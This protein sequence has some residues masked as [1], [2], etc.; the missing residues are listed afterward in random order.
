MQRQP[1]ML[2]DPSSI[3][4]TVLSGNVHHASRDKGILTRMQFQDVR[5]YPSFE[6]SK[7][8]LRDGTVQI[9]LIDSSLVDMDGLDCLRAIARDRGLPVK[10]LVMVTSECQREYVLN[11]VTSGCSGYVIRP[12][13]LETL[14]KH[15]RTA[16]Q[17]LSVGEIEQEMLDTAKASLVRGDFDAAISEFEEVVSEENEALKYFNMGMEYLR[18]KSFGKAILSF[19]KAVALNELYA[20]A[21]RGLAYAHKGKGDDAAYHAHLTRAADLFAM[22]D[23]LQELKE[24]F[25]EILT[26]DPEAINPYNNLGVK[27]RRSGDYLGALHA[28]NQALLLTPTDE[29]LHYNIA[30]AH[31]YAGDNQKA[32]GHL[33]EAVVIRG[34]FREAS[35]L[36]KK[37][38][39]ADGDADNDAASGPPPGGAAS[40]PESGSRLPID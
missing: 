26:D 39:G 14:E 16:W 22:Q 31:I 4:V 18:A 7:D 12:Y 2:F 28:Y 25:G 13:S 34:D 8:H 19:N 20:E 10:A 6:Q 35:A 32:L 3:S 36:I 24:V 29:N 21:H 40:G 27:L 9:A 30:K 5:A 33:R 37:L 23:K 15:I 1:R 17:S 11:A 38:E